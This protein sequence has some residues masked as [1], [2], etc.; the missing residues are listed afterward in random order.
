MYGDCNGI[1]YRHSFCLFVWKGYVR[2]DTIYSFSMEF[3][4]FFFNN[5]CVGCN[6]FSICMLIYIY[7]YIT[8][9]MVLVASLLIMPVIG[10]L[11]LNGILESPQKVGLL[12]FV[13]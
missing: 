2:L 4:F 11:L 12:L 1:L 9:V 13:M 5:K 3:F 7:I 6:I 8:I 10:I